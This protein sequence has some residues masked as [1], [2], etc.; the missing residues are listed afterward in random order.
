MPPLQAALKRRARDRLRR[1]RDDDHAGGRLRAAR[2]P[3]R[4]TGRLFIGVRA[5]ARRRRPGLR[6]RR[7]DPVADDVLEAA[8]APG[9]TVL[10]RSSRPGSNGLNRGYRALSARHPAASGGCGRAGWC[11]R[12][13]ASPC[14]LF[15]QL[16]SELSPIE[17][18]G[19]IFGSCIAPEGA[20]R[21]L[22]PTSYVQAAWRRSSPRQCRTSTRLS[23]RSSASRR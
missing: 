6:L 12:S 23:S 1:D 2:V 5:D 22:T 3:D 8:A 18:R 19:I 15:K 14:F 21:R 7:A 11:C 10:Y 4:R 17:D 9:S 20:T 16:P 13:P